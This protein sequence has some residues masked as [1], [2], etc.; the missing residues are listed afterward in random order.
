[1][2]TYEYVVGRKDDQQA[3]GDASRDQR[4]ALVES[5]LNLLTEAYFFRLHPLR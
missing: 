4:D 3:E 1:M 5:Q 2:L